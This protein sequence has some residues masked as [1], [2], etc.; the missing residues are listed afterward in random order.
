LGECT[1]FAIFLL[2]PALVRANLLMDKE[3]V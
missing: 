2:S 3:K 1:V